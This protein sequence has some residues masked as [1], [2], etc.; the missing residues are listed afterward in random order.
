M[1]DPV[2]IEIKLVAT[3]AMLEKL[4][5]NPVLAGNEQV[6]TL[7][8][9]YFDTRGGRLRR[10][11]AALRI[12]D[13]EKGREQTLKLA[14][15]NEGSVRRNE[16]NV[17]LRGDHPE[18]DNFPAM[19]RSALISLLDGEG[20]EP[21]AT[22]HIERTTRQVHFG[23]SAIEVAFDLGAI[24]A[25]GRAEPVCE[26]EMEMV[27]GRLAD[28]IAL[29]LRLPLG[30]ELTWSVRSKAERCHALAY[31]LPLKAIHARAVALSPASDVAQGFQMIAWNCLDQIL[32]NYP[33]V[34]ASGDPEAVHQTRVAI[35]RL[36]AA[37]SIFA[38]V[39]D[40]TVEPVLRA[41]LKAAASALASTRDLDVLIRRVASG[42]AAGG[43]ILGEV[44]GHLA[45]K[46]AKVVVS[47]QAAL[48]SDSFQRLLFGLA[49]WLE[50][51]EWLRRKSETG[52]DLP[53]RPFAARSLARRRRQLRQTKKHLADLSEAGRHKLRIRVKK[54]RYANAFFASLFSG[55]AERHRTAVMKSLD[56]LQDSLGDLNDMVVAKAHR[57]ALFADLD[58]IAA[59]AQTVQLDAL[60]T[61]Q[62]KSRRKLIKLAQ[63]S[64]DWI[65]RAPAW[66]KV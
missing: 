61:R 22:T 64:F 50:D 37:M 63:N 12:R 47:A 24:E 4:R 51:G 45:A 20:L 52:G 38:D 35:R 59:A 56:Q 66:W 32:A 28:V 3:S 36:R 1:A 27:E 6:S 23:Q 55:N 39:T 54:L 40:D 29:A 58:A 21:V 41:E 5:F 34:I 16:W 10:A 43:D 7:T 9:T 11:G 33:L 53:L 17:E 42:V 46:R 13:S 31:G 62:Q 25:N 14:P 8:T 65:V 48:R 57:E 18:P 60:V 26:L 19:A 2:E 15:P 49:A 44:I 30:T